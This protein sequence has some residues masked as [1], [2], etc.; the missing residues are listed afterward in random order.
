M[1][2]QIATTIHR[3][4]RTRAQRCIAA[5]IHTHPSRVGRIMRRMDEVAAV[6]AV[7]AALG[8]Q[9]VPR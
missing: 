3:R 7:L 9:V 1:A 8:L 4:A 6:L 5:E 2:A